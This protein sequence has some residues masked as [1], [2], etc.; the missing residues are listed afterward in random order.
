MPADR[1]GRQRLALPEH[2][3]PA[4]AEH[5]DGDQRVVEPAHLAVGVQPLEV[6]AVAIEQCPD[7]AELDAIPSNEVHRRLSQE[8]RSI[9]VEAG[10][11]PLLRHVLVVAEDLVL[12]PGRPVAHGGE[13]RVGV[14]HERV[15]DVHPRRVVELPSCDGRGAIDPQPV[16]TGVGHTAMIAAPVLASVPKLMPYVVAQPQRDATISGNS[17]A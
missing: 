9:R 4:L 1:V 15:D 3:R 14:E 13:L 10:A 7:P 5:D 8:R 11:E 16:G 17:G 6:L 2:E 12:L